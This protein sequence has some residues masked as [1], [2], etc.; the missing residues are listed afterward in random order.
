MPP[1]RKKKLND[2]NMGVVIRS[3]INFEAFLI[4][5]LIISS[6]FL[7]RRHNVTTRAEMK[8]NLCKLQYCEI[9]VRFYFLTV[10]FKAKQK[11]E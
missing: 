3:G 1:D 11:N 9:F 6:S 8:R 7:P 5:P 10:T 4:E 2:K